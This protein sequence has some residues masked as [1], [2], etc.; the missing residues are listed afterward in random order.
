MMGLESIS[1]SISLGP[2]TGDGCWKLI[3][4]IVVT[5][6]LVTLTIRIKFQFSGMS[7]VLH[8]F[9]LSKTYHVS[10]FKYF[11]VAATWESDK[12]WRALE[13]SPCLNEPTTSSSNMELRAAILKAS[14][15]DGQ[16]LVVVTGTSNEVVL[17]NG[18][19]ANIISGIILLRLILYK[20]F[21]VFL[22]NKVN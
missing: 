11:V 21:F 22:N 2:G 16:L 15:T 18:L 17:C 14:C 9:S 19:L 7:N 5:L 10:S 13:L 4:C 3:V 8:F 1:A 20:Y 6:C 12:Y